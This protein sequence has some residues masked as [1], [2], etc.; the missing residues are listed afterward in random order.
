MRAGAKQKVNL[1]RP[2]LQTFQKMGEAG[3]EYLL[4][5]YVYE[6]SCSSINFSNTRFQA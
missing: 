1:L 6:V 2:I 4:R 5:P 3:E